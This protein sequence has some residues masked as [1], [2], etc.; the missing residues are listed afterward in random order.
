[1]PLKHYK[2]TSPA[3]RLMTTPDNAEITKGKRPERKLTAPLRKSGGRNSYGHITSRHI[4]GGHKRR[5]RIIDWKRNKDG[6]EG[7][8]VAIEYDP[9]RSAR[10]ALIQ[11]VD[12]EKRYILWPEGL[13]VGDRV[14]SG[15]DVDPQPGNA[16]P[17]RTIPLGALIHNVELKPGRGGQL[18]RSAGSW[19]QLMAKE[20]KFA[21]IR[22]PSGEVRMVLLECRATIGALGH[23]EHGTVRIGKAGRSRW[24]G[25][26][27]R[28]RGVAMNPVDHPH[29]GGEGKAA[30]GNPHPVTPWGVPTKGHKTRKNKNTD[31]FIVKRRK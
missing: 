12:G 14:L 28:V 2:P 13:K 9:N 30:Q 27:P 6:I 16:L 20:G 25:R 24:L 21:Q 19:G 26:R 29:G 4:G 7:R 10:I 18:I 15:E 3:R 5:Y 23:S 22:M 17:L 31:K 11:Y 1:M 8:V